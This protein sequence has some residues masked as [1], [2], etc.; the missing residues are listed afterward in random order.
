MVV[1]VLVFRLEGDGRL[2]YREVRARWRSSAAP[3]ALALSVA[4]IT[5]P[6]ARCRAELWQAIIELGT[7][8]AVGSHEK[9]HA[10]DGVRRTC[11]PVP[12]VGVEP[13]LGPF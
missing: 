10:R 9:I 7:R 2:A 6:A 1:E 8:M 5:G 4:G 11:Q 12:P 13:T 3:D